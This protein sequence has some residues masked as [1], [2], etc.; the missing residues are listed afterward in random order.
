MA[1]YFTLSEM[2]YSDTANRKGIKNTPNIEQVRNINELMIFL[3]G[4][5]EAWGSG[6][7]IN[8]GFRCEKLNSLVGGCKTSA[9][10]CGYA[11]DLYP[12]NGNFNTFKQFIVKYLKSKNYDQCIIERSGCSQWVHLGLKNSSGQQRKQCFSLNV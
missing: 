11:A 4:I 6:I 1:K 9:H 3:D 5:R 12:C 10:K 2:C 7:R 8:S